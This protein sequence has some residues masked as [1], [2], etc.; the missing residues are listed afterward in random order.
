MSK[1]RSLLA[2]VGTLVL[3]GTSYLLVSPKEGVTRADLV[4]AGIAQV[5]EPA[6]IECRVRSL[7]SGP[8]YRLVRTKAA[9]CDRQGAD[10]VLVMRWP[11]QS[12]RPCF[13]TVGDPSDACRLI[14]A[15][16]TCNDAALCAEAASGEQPVA[17]RVDVCACRRATGVCE[18]QDGDGGWR[19]APLGNTLAAGTFRGAGCA[20]KYCGPEAQGEQGMSWDSAVCPP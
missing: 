7:C 2:V 11:K 10:P 4:D 8:R 19:P 20:P 9:V 13:E 3:G 15:P 17:D 18:V 12:G 5:C 6:L 14:T 1:L 16:G